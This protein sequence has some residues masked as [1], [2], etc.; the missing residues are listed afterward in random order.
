MMCPSLTVVG[1]AGAVGRLLAEAFADR[2]SRLTVIDLCLPH[3]GG[4]SEAIVADVTRPDAAAR[5]VLRESDVV[6]LALPEEVALGGLPMIAPLLRT[7]CLLVDTLSVKTHFAHAVRTIRPTRG[8]L[9]INP[10]FRPAGEIAGHAVAVVEIVAGLNGDRFRADLRG[11]GA[12]L[13]ELTVDQHDRLLAALQ[14]VVHAAI[15][16]TGVALRELAIDLDA[17]RALAPRPYA[18][19]LSSL[20]RILSG[21]PEVYREIQAGNP[22]AEAARAELADGIARVASSSTNRA[23]FDLL[24]YELRETYSIAEAWACEQPRSAEPRKAPED[25]IDDNL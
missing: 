21:K 22:Y 7:D 8:A 3:T 20:V 25:A 23:T 19:V 14:A 13:W 2:F 18:A 17:A 11:L 9:G 4:V 6:V 12:E 24:F 16:G 10:M 5:Q 15:I 1:G